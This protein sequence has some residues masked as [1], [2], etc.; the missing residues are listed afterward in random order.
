MTPTLLIKPLARHHAQFLSLLGGIILLVTLL[1]CNFFW[2]QAKLP[3]MLLIL[4]ALVIIFIGILKISEPL[5]SFILTPHKLHFAHRYGAWELNWAEIHYIN[6]VSETYGI[7][8][9][10]LPYIGIR[11]KELTEIANNISPRLASRLLHEQRPLLAFCLRHQLI[12]LEQGVINFSAYQDKNKSEII[13]PIA[14]FLHQ[15]ELLKN[16]LGYHLYIPETALDRDIHDFITL[17][18]NCKNAAFDSSSN[19]Y[20]TNKNATS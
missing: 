11:L 2:H 20:N 18:K 19:K 4:I 13:G 16:A 9:H 6:Q 1:L 10:E 5:H 12:S 3:L 7:E 8:R 17:L 15:S 14:A